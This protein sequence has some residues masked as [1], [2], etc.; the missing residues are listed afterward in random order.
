MIT[1]LDCNKNYF[2][3]IF[4]QVMITVL[5]CNKNILYIL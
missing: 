4:V 3:Y 5:D 2:L 1:A